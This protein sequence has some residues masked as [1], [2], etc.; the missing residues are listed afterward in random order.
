MMP[1]LSLAVLSV[2]SMKFM[3]HSGLR[4]DASSIKVMTAKA[5]RWRRQMSVVCFREFFQTGEHTNTGLWTRRA[6]LE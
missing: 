3:K 6:T 2:F 4:E 5:G 1:G